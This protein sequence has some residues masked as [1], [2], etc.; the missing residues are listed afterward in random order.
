VASELLFL[1]QAFNKSRLAR[2]LNLIH[3]SLQEIAKEQGIRNK[4]PKL[5]TTA[6]K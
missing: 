6:S 3:K 1:P 5:T 4:L 2:Q